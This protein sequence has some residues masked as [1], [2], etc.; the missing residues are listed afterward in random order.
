MKKALI[1]DFDGT[2]VDSMPHWGGA[3]LRFLDAQHLSY[4]TDIIEHITPL[5]N[6][7]AVNYFRHHLGLTAT[8]EEAIAFIVAD[9]LP[10]YRDEILLKE[11]ADA[12]LRRAKAQGYTLAV[13]TAS[14][15]VTLDPCLKRNDVFHLFDAVWSCEDF[16]TTKSDPAIYI[17]AATRLGVTIEQ[18]AFYDDNLHAIA[19]AK[20]AGMH[21]VGVYDPSGDS[22]AEE[23][24]RTAEQYIRSFAELPI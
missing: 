24:K 7:G 5:G 2:L 19:T 14:P 11:G 22:F 1:F 15:H 18:C 20:A 4:P 3:M 17:T 6:T 16:G 23:L 8:D 10:H 13:L 9:M 21:T 12:F